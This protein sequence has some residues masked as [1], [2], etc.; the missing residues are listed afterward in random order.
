MPQFPDFFQAAAR[1][2]QRTDSAWYSGW[3]GSNPLVNASLIRA[4]D[5]TTPPAQEHGEVTI[6]FD[7]FEIVYS[8]ST[9]GWISSSPLSLPAAGLV[10]VPLGTADI[11]FYH[12]VTM[13]SSQV[14]WRKDVFYPGDDE[15]GAPLNLPYTVRYASGDAIPSLANLGSLKN[16]R[17]EVIKTTFPGN[18]LLG[19]TSTR[20]FYNST[21]NTPGSG[22]FIGL[23]GGL[24][25]WSTQLTWDANLGCPG[26]QATVRD[27][28]SGMNQVTDFYVQWIDGSDVYQ[29]AIC[30]I[31]S[32]TAGYVTIIVPATVPIGQLVAVYGIFPGTNPAPYQNTQVFLGSFTI[33]Q[34]C[35]PVTVT[36]DGGV[37]IGQSGADITRVLG[38]NNAAAP[39]G[40]QVGAQGATI[41]RIVELPLA[42][43]G[44]G[45]LVGGGNAS[46]PN[47]RSPSPGVGGGGEL[48]TIS[49]A[50]CPPDLASAS[51]AVGATGCA[52]TIPAGSDSG[53][54][55]G[56]APV[57]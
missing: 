3:Q 10:A 44:N 48:E 20:Y 45:V 8:S 39:G 27:G 46:G 12:G 56:C 29:E 35:F 41:T 53:G 43:A 42:G 22:S 19:T 7:F 9:V 55:T 18:T 51:G 47:V 40:V 30:T 37:R 14:G 6:I 15:T 11:R 36:G 16:A 21:Y 32:R 4:G 5:P 1:I 50:G 52:P 49:G 25:V 54:G 23:W 57:L 31:V 17:V 2:T 26:T 24:S 13:S 38:A 28:A 34:N 33:P